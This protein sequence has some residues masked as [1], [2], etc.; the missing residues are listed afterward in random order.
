MF[1][2]LS[3]SLET[4]QIMDLGQRDQRGVAGDIA[5]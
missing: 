5:K 4:Q 2:K 3:D 1:Y